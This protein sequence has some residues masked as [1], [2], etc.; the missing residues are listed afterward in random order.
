VRQSLGQEV[1]VP[2][3]RMAT[4]QAQKTSLMPEGLEEG[5][6]N[7]DMADLLEFIFSDPR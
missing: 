1:S 4:I 6:A 2:R 3:S 5:L 7:Q